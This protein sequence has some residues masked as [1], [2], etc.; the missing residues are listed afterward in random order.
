MAAAVGLPLS[1]DKETD[2]SE[3]LSVPAIL[4]EERG[5]GSC[6]SDS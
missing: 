4:R 5:W 2:G 3:G 1:A 6:A